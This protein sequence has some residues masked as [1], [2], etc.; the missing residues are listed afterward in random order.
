MIRAAPRR[1]Q[2]EYRTDDYATQRGLEQLLHAEFLPPLNKI[3]PIRP[4]NRRDRCLHAS[5]AGVP[6]KTVMARKLPYSEGDV[7]A[8]PLP[9]GGYGVGVVTRMD[10]KGSVLG[11]FLRRAPRRDG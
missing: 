10:G 1:F 8:V 2:P 6:S 11:Y 4:A 5:G 3:R 7:F 9:D